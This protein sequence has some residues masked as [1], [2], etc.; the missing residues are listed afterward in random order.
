MV[1]LRENRHDTNTGVVL[2]HRSEISF[3]DG[4]I[5]C[6]TYGAGGRCRY[7]EVVEFHHSHGRIAY[8]YVGYSIFQLGCGWNDDNAV[9]QFREKRSQRMAYNKK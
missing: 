2:K 5:F 8:G 7:S 9:T 3:K 4:R 6:G 1:N